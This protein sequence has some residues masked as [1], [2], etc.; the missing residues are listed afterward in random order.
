M[1]LLI[2]IPSTA[3][4]PLNSEATTRF[5]CSM[6][7]KQKPE[8]AIAILIQKHQ[9]L[10]QLRDN[11][12]TIAYPGYW[13]FFGGHIEPG[14]TAEAGVW[15]ELKEEIGY[16]PPWLKPFERRIGEI[17]IRNI[18]YGPLTAPIDQLELN[19]GWDLALWTV[20]EI[21][22]GD[23]YS[24]NAQQVRP[25]GQPHRDI[26]LSFIQQYGTAAV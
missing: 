20:A 5:Q 8:V 15:R 1:A 9:F 16:T 14:E 13:A 18:F 3:R 26:L 22:R 23:R 25:L 2:K 19:E 12:P 4:P 24:E 11:I 21:Q 7:A 6:A 17:S 10:L